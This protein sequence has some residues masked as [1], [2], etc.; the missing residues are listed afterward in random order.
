MIRAAFEDVHIK[1]EY[2]LLRVLGEA[3]FIRA[4]SYN[5]VNLTNELLETPPLRFNVEHPLEPSESSAI[6]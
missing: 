4:L 6:D 2:S 5:I 1:P 3:G